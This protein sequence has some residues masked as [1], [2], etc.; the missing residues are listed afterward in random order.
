MRCA[1]RDRPVFISGV[2]ESI[3]LLGRLFGHSYMLT[4]EGIRVAIFYTKLRGRLLRPL[5]DTDQPPIPILSFVAPWPSS[6]AC[7][8][9]T[10]RTLDW[11][12]PPET[13]H[14]TRDLGTKK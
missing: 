2:D 7:L 1:D 11:E 14:K 9:T 10:S 6:S 8:A 5:L 12:R 3:E 13:C 4:P